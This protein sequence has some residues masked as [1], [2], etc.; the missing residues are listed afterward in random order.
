MENPNDLYVDR[1]RLISQI[2]YKDKRILSKAQ[3]KLS[4][5][6]EGILPFANLTTLY[7]YRPI[8]KTIDIAAVTQ[9]GLFG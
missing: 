6:N 7:N 5:K 3:S 1:R 4:D 9:F 2:H 8:K